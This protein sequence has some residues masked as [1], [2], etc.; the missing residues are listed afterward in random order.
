MLIQ[1]HFE[2][3]SVFFITEE[4]KHMR[5]YVLDDEMDHYDKNKD[6]FVDIDEFDSKSDYCL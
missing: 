6:G 2:I 1:S 3:Y 5:E 4:N